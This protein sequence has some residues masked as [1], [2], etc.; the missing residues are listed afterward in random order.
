MLKLKQL[1]SNGTGPNLEGRGGDTYY[2]PPLEACVVLNFVLTYLPNN[3]C[4]FIQLI[5]V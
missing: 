3:D 2:P 1:L 5:S 4:L